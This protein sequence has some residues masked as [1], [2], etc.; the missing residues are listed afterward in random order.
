MQAIIY[1]PDIAVINVNGTSFVYSGILIRTDWLVTSGLRTHDV[2]DSKGFPKQTLLAR[3]GAVTIDSRFTLNEDEDEQEH[4]VIQIVRPYNHSKKASWLKT[5]ISLIKT[6]L[7]FTITPAVAMKKINIA[8]T[9][10]D[11]TCIILVYTQPYMYQ[12]LSSWDTFITCG[13][14]GKCGEEQ[15]GNICDV[16][17]KDK[18]SSRKGFNEPETMN[19]EEPKLPEPETF[20]PEGSTTAKT[21][22][23]TPEGSTI[24]E[25][26]TMHFEFITTAESE[27]IHE[28]NTT[29][30]TET[31]TPEETT[32]AETET[33]TP[34]TSTTTDTETI[35]PE[36]DTATELVK[37][38]T[39]TPTNILSKPTPTHTPKYKSWESSDTTL[40]DTTFTDFGPAPDDMEVE[41][42]RARAL[43]HAAQ[44]KS[45]SPSA[46][47]RTTYLVQ[48]VFFVLIWRM[49]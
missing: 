2:S 37:E 43:A 47:D 48:T 28:G 42:I 36:P 29:A 12:L 16:T 18:P 5:D 17:Y 1:Y 9:F 3:L 44:M 38:S 21:E 34:T 39:S 10:Q 27:A 22:T 23:M 15:S 26:E 46:T 13:I 30:E 25:N 31:I 19:P 33:I 35:I 4:E 7:P 49:L 11:K 41:N 32:T 40:R 8:Q 45:H 20:T 14:E 24:V 6:L